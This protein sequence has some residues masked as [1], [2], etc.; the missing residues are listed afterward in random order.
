MSVSTRHPEYTTSRLTEWELMRH[1]YEGESAIKRY[2]ELYLPLLPGWRDVA[3]RD[4]LYLGYI[5]RARFPEIVSSAIRSMIGIVH[6]KDWQIELPG[7]EYL[8]ERATKDGLTLDAFTRRVTLELLTTGRYAVI[9]DAPNTERGGDPYLCGYNAESFINWDEND[10]SFYVFQEEK[11]V[12]NGFVWRKVLRTR[13][14][15]LVDGR[16][17]QSVYDDGSLVD[18]I[19]P[20]LPNRGPM[21]FIP[22]AV[23]GAMDMDLKPDT[24][25]LIGV[26][27]AAVSH[28]QIY[29]DWRTA[30]FMAY[31]DTLVIHNASDDSLPA[32]VG[33]GV[34]ISLKSAEIGKDTRAEYLSP[35]GKS[36]EAHER[37][38]DREQQTAIR[39][40][41]ALFDNTEGSGQ[42]S[43]EARRLRFSAETATLQSIANASAAIVEKAIRNAAMMK[44]LA[45]EGIIV[46]PPTDMLEG[47][48]DATGI[49]ALVSA[50]EKRAFSYTTLHENLQRGGV[51]SMDRTPDDEY[52]LIESEEVRALP[53]DGMV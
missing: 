41:A 6:G 13:V 23:G 24:P 49:T 22:V 20:A 8:H 12:R 16:Y 31:Q 36:I 11:N 2:T 32:S 19:E 9:S 29:A 18:M 28:Y 50:W 34:M 39:S 17:V 44:G 1:A 26:A 46:K 5:R 4:E 10:Q 7:M 30:L 21:N 15:E 33:A 14:L 45:P 35:S 43:G 52:A 25:P 27:R 51:V 48:L 53:S 47:R 40:G 37:G 3:N 38:M 42:E